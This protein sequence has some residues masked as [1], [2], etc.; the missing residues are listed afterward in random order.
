MNELSRQMRRRT[1]QAMRLKSNAVS[2]HA[3]VHVGMYDQ[4]V[5]RYVEECEEGGNRELLVGKGPAGP[6]PKD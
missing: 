4:R 3:W 1:T 5:T 2:V 6:G